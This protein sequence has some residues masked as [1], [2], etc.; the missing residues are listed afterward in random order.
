M[1]FWWKRSCRARP[2]EEPSL[3]LQCVVLRK[4]GGPTLLDNRGAIR[5]SDSIKGDRKHDWKLSAHFSASIFF[6]SPPSSPHIP[7]CVLLCDWLAF[8]RITCPETVG[9]RELACAR[10]SSRPCVFLYQP[11]LCVCV[12]IWVCVWVCVCKTGG[13][14]FRRLWALAFTR[15]RTEAD[16]KINPAAHTHTQTHA[17]AKVVRF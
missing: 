4:K 14:R 9:R 7:V 3:R 5:G 6:F 2:G 10:A 17:Q 1:R 11:V 12:W 13:I 8:F 15:R 16:S